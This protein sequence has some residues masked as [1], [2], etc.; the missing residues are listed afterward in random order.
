MAGAWSVVFLFLSG[1]FS[2]A[3]LVWSRTRFGVD[4]AYNSP[5]TYFA[6]FSEPVYGSICIALVLLFAAL[7]GLHGASMRYSKN[8]LRLGLL[9]IAACFVYSLYFRV[10]E[11]LNSEFFIWGWV[12]SLLLLLT[13]LYFCFHGKNVWEQ[14]YLR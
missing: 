3:S 6:V 14:F 13:L 9:I 8:M 5:E 11:L 12:S 1:F 4:S 10:L 2:I 7:A